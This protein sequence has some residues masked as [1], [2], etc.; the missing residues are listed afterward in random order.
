MYDTSTVKKAQAYLWRFLAPA[1]NAF[2]LMR[3]PSWFLD[4]AAYS[5]VVQNT[6]PFLTSTH[7]KSCF[8]LLQTVLFFFKTHFSVQPD[9]SVLLFDFRFCLRFDADCAVVLLWVCEGAVAVRSTTCTRSVGI[10]TVVCTWAWTR[11]R[12]LNDRVA[13]R[14]ARSSFG[15]RRQPRV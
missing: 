5:Q 10:T 15:P 8:H 1:T 12:L 6:S 7:P 3:R 9:L 13:A 11:K 4:R 2:F 14:V